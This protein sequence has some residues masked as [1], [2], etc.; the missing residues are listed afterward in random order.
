MIYQIDDRQPVF[1]TER[2]FV[3][4]NATLIGSVR[5][6]DAA[7]VW[8]NAVLR[9]DNE[10]IHIGASSNIQDGAV[11]HTDPGFPLSLGQGVTVGHKAMLHGCSVGDY[12]LIGINAVVLNGARIGRH[13]L[14]GAN[15]LVP[16]GME[17][18]DGS[19]VLGSPARVKRALT[20]PQ[21]EALRANAESY[22]RQMERYRAALRVLE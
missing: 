9:A 20:D 8:F 5:L 22:V 4:D 6:G 12:S 7:S 19:L 10:P 14:V 16:E 17:V 1:A 3:A 11:L 13:C 15:A 2:Y 21:I 18:P